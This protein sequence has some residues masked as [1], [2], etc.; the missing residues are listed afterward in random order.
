NRGGAYLAP[1]DNGNSFSLA[2][3]VYSRNLWTVERTDGWKFYFPYR[4]H[5]IGANVTVL[6]GFSDATGH[7]YEMVRDESGD[8]LSVTT[9]SNYSLHFERDSEHRVESITD[10]SG[11]SVRY[12]YD[13]AGRLAHVKDSDGNEESYTYDDKAEMISVSFDSGAPV[14]KNAYSID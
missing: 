12:D 3:A 8:L 4:P 5:A 13:A 11:R 14:V 9:P 10:S 1:Q 6:T 2:R 7:E